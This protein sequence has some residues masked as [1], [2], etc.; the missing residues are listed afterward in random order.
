[1]KIK[2]SILVGILAAGILSAPAMAGSTGAKGGTKTATIDNSVDKSTTEVIGTMTITG[3]WGRTHKWDWRHWRWVPV[4]K[5]SADAVSKTNV[6]YDEVTASTYTN[7]SNAEVEAMIK[8]AGK[9]LDKEGEKCVQS[10]D[11][12]SYNGYT[13]SDPETTKSWNH[14]TF[15]YVDNGLTG[16]AMLIGDTDYMNGAY[17]ASGDAGRYMV[18]EGD[19]GKNWVYRV[20][21]EGFVSPI[22]LDLDGDGKIEASNG[23]YMPHAGDVAKSK[24]AVMFDF[25]GNGFPV[26]MEWVGANDGLLCRPH[27]DGSIDG[28]CLFGISNGHDNGYEE[29]SALDIDRNGNLEGAELEGLMIWTDKNCNGVAEQ[30]EVTSLETLGI[31]SIGVNHNNYVGNYVRNGKSFKTFDWWPCVVN[32]RKVNLKKI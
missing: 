32:C 8:E 18:I 19:F 15:R 17:A 6:I 21:G 4:E 5:D 11:R 23:K 24:Y 3:V 7:P 13:V 22:V 30:G 27:K 16:D 20:E 31:T 9:L 28:T 26:A 2:Y 12:G 10:G 1:M 29:L 25:Y 14:V